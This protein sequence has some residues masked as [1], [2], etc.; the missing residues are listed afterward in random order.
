MPQAGSKIV[1][2]QIGV[3]HLDHERADL[4]RRA[5]L[6]VQRR[7]AEVCQQI[8]E[9]VALDIR[10]RACGTSIPSSSS[11]TCFS[12]FGSTISSTASRKYSATCGSSL[13][14]EAMYG[15]TSSRTKSRRSCRS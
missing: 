13:T 12:T 9:D 5:E 3:D 2:P 1:S 8:F 4:A 7:L 15:K 6:A 10:C 14:S 11:I